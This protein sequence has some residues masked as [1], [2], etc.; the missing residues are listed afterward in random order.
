MSRLWG[1]LN[2]AER[3]ND[4]ERHAR[5]RYEHRW[6]ELAGYNSR[7]SKG[8]V[9]TPEYVARM[10]AEQAR[11]DAERMAEIEADP[12]NHAIP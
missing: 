6:D 5:W 7:V 8:I 12:Y 2:L 1:V 3:L 4:E 11:F 10:A 9:H